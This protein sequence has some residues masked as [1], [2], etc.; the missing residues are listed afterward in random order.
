MAGNPG[1]KNRRRERRPKRWTRSVAAAPVRNATASP[2]R[3]PV[4]VRPAIEATKNTPAH[5]SF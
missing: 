4:I 2:S 5:R 1:R 3:R